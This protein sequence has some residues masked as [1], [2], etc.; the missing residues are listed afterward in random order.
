MHMRM[1][2][3]MESAVM[4]GH[5]AVMTTCMKLEARQPSMVS[6]SPAVLCKFNGAIIEVGVGLHLYWH[7]SMRLWEPDM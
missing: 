4:T 3:P 1:T 2:M 6:P 5:H 7:D